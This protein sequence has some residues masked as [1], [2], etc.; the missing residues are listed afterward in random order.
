MTRTDEGVFGDPSA[1]GHGGNDNWRVREAYRELAD[2]APD[3]VDRLDREFRHLYI[4]A[5]G[6]SL[7]GRTPAEVIGKT[8]RE[9]GV[10]DPTASIWEER[11]R[12]VFETGEPLEVEDSF[13]TIHGIRFFGTRCVPERSADGSVQTVLT[14]SRDITDRKRAEEALRESEELFRTLFESSSAATAIIERDTTISMVNREY[15]RLLGCPAQDAVGL[16][17]TT[18]IF[19][20]DLPR[21]Q[22]DNRKRL[23]DPQS[24]PDHYE[25][26][27]RRTDGTIRNALIHLAVIPTSQKILCTFVDITERKRAEA[28]KARLETQLRQA[29][30][31]ESVGRLAGG[32]AHDFNNMLGVILGHADLALE[33]LGETHPLYH[34]L[35]EI[36]TAAS[37]SADL[38]RQLLAFARKQTITPTALDLNGT[39][40]RM[41]TMLRR[42]IGEDVEL[43]WRPGR[44]AWLI[45]MDASQID[46]MLANLCVNARDAIT[47]VGR[48]TIETEN[49]TL[50]DAYC[51]DHP[52]FVPGEYLRLAVSDDGCGMDK[53]TQAH[54]FEP[55]FTTKAVGKGTGLGL[56]TVYGIVKQNHGFI[57]VYS[58]LGVGTTFTIYLPRHLDA[59]G[60][61]RTMGVADR[62]IR[63]HETILVVED[64][65]AVLKMTVRM[66][67]GQGYTVLAARSA[68]EAIRLAGEYGTAIH[69]VVTDVVMPGMNGRELAAKLLSLYPHL[70]RLF[71]SGYT[72][73]VIAHHGVLEEGMHFLQKPF[74]ISELATKVR[75]ALDGS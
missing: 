62:V 74:S 27:F 67:A 43:V 26:R 69:L 58:E 14:V 44:N 48:V 5:A 9:L 40:A 56:A 23:A 16:S 7:V 54:L 11:L 19:Q 17:W 55:F 1:R 4:N 32:V 2:N 51:A 72:A 37:R 57:N 15:C 63:G 49:T 66:L 3:S 68:V 8:N 71:T 24:V 21:M 39:V 6:A 36:R 52:G 59:G 35:V 13:P 25:F 50:D 10:P 46:Q 12:R 38:T 18:Q 41:L 34:D 60:S 33:D 20:D 64:D 42:L 30:K 61:A 53:D 70:K 73:D 75:E 31:M 29:Q 65:P 45:K 28:E 22:E 47:G